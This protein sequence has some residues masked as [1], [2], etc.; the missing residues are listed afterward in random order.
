MEAVAQRRG[1]FEAVPQP[2]MQLIRDFCRERSTP[3]PLQR[4]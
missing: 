3:S 4:Q 1:V 2:M